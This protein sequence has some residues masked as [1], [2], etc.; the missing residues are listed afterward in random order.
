MFEFITARAFQEITLSKWKQLNEISKSK[1]KD[2]N[3]SNIDKKQKQM[4]AR[5]GRKRPRSFDYMEDNPDNPD[6]NGNLNIE[7][8]GQVVGYWWALLQFFLNYSRSV[9]WGVLLDE[10]EAVVKLK[11]Q[12]EEQQT[13]PQWSTWIQAL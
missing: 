3:L 5:S 4:K 12:G 1:V 6:I 2:L 7:A 10:E 9:Q 11:A 13:I 8:P